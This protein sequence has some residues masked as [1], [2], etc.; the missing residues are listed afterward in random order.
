MKKNFLCTKDV[1]MVRKYTETSVCAYFFCIFVSLLL[2]GNQNFV[3]PASMGVERGH[4][5]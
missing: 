4:D 1:N 5:Y 3:V 2:E